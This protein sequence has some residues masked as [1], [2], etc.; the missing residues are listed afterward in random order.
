[1]YKR[2]YPFYKHQAICVTKQWEADESVVDENAKYSV[3][4]DKE[5]YEA[6]GIR[7]VEESL[8]SIKNDKD[9]QDREPGKTVSKLAESMLSIDKNEFKNISDYFC[10]KMYLYVKFH[11]QMKV[12]YL[13]A[14]FHN[15]ALD[16]GNDNPFFQLIEKSFPQT[17]PSTMFQIYQYFLKHF[18]QKTLALCIKP[19]KQAL[20]ISRISMTRD[21]ESTLRYVAGFLIFSLKRKLRGK[22]SSQAKAVVALLETACFQK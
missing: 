2:S 21:E 17:Q 7:L 16:D 20:D 22:T 1:M 5:A 12:D 18:L 14:K 6:E 10:N 19:N 11:K 8:K 9:L 15:M 4:K 13:S 3:I